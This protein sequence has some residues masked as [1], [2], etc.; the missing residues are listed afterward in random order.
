MTTRNTALNFAVLL[1]EQD[2]NWA[3]RHAHPLIFLG[4]CQRAEQPVIADRC[5]RPG[6]AV[7]EE[8]LAQINGR[9]YGNDFALSYEIKD[10]FALSYEIKDNFASSYETK[11]VIADGKTHLAATGF[12]INLRQP[13]IV[14]SGAT[15][16]RRA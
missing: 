10:N 4:S 13:L 15:L 8:H 9:Q 16:T 7:D 1:R 11:K 14:H 12:A 3:M 5:R 2:A 6:S